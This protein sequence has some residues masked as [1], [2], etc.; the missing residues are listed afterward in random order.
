MDL[1]LVLRGML[2]LFVVSWHVTGYRAEFPPLVNIPGRVAVWIFFGISG[3]VIAHGFIS[4]RYKYCVSDLKDFYINRFLRIYPL[5]F[6][7]SLIG[8]I[9]QWVITGNNPLS[10][11]DLPGQF[12]DLQFNQGDYPL[13][14]VFWSLGIEIHFYLI[15]P[16]IALLFLSMLP[17]SRIL[18]ITLGIVLYLAVT[19]LNYYLV[20]NQGWSYDGRN[21]VASLPHFIVGMLSC[22]VV[23]ELKPNVSR[24]IFFTVS[25]FALLGYI[26]WIY[27]MQPG[28]FWSTQGILLVDLV[29]FTFVL[30]HA[31][32][33]AIESKTSAAYRV[34]SYLGVL[35]Y[36]IYAW[37][38]V[39]MQNIPTLAHNVLA[40]MI[41][42]IAA[43]HVT[44][45]IIE[46]PALKLKR[47]HERR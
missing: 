47:Y 24:L 1:L 12:F 35:S 7:L 44:Y 5:F 28:R 43:A 41:L 9:A 31:N 30:A 38:L 17:V 27:H 42:S 14:G 33:K 2:S 40:I 29:I 34:A 39:L 26:N 22:L 8:W 46:A 13:D 6:S 23:F 19:F 20:K 32:L 45:R 18:A 36:G 3:Y 11:S 15:A 16:L 4:K 21:I 10:L 25:A 37:H